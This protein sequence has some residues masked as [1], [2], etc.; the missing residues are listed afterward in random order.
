MVGGLHHYGVGDEVWAQHQAD[1]DESTRL[2]GLTSCAEGEGER[3]GRLPV[4][5]GGEGD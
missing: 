1:G 5:E 2:L 4:K 3:E